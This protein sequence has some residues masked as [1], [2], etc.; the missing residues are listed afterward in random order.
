MPFPYKKVLVVGAT[1]GIGE[2]LATKLVSQGIKVVVAGRRKEK[3]DAFVR[4]HGSDK[5][6]AVVFD[7][8][9]LAQIPSF[10]AAVTAAHPDLDCVFLNS[11][12][13]R[14]MNFTRPETLDLASFDN[15]LT[16]NYTSFI[17]LTV[18]FLPFLQQ[19]KSR[20]GIIYTTSALALTPMVRCPN[21]CATKAALHHFVLALRQQ[22]TDGGF[23]VQVIEIFPPAVQTE[24]HD[25][26]VQPDIKDGRQMG[27]PL[28]QFVDEAW[29]GLD[30]AKDQIPVGW[31][32]VAFDGWEQERQKGFSDF[33]ESLAPMTKDFYAHG[34]EA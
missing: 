1:S 26:A 22:M 33:T 28:Q 17:H 31:A 13:Q 16:T 6:S 30:G 5:A 21:Y 24:L 9:Q 2:A 23:D 27:I 10:A 7:V 4:T 12:I 32:R 8:T 14:G 11:G 15:E 25:A 34:S 19:K 29:A 18:A 20:T 3:L